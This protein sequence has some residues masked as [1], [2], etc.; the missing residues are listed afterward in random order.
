MTKLS[1]EI[2]NDLNSQYDFWARRRELWRD[3]AHDVVRMRRLG[4]LQ[5]TMERVERKM[6]RANNMIGRLIKRFDDA[7]K[8]EEEKNAQMQMEK[9]ELAEFQR[10][11]LKYGNT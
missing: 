3:L 9:K 11:K 5:T 1:D 8:Q 4:G 10:L 2:M 6:V 7:V